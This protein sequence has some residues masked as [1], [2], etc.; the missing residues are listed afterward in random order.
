M[1]IV[2]FT[3]YFSVPLFGLE[4]TKNGRVTIGIEWADG[5]NKFNYSRSFVLH[6]SES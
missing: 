2:G 6:K 4:W 5:R 1:V 3:K